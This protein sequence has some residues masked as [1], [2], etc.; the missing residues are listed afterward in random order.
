MY[1]IYPLI[2]HAAPGPVSITSFPSFFKI[3]ITWN[4]PDIP[5]GIIIAYEVSYWA[6][7]SS[8]PVTTLNTTDLATSFTTQS[9][10]EV[11]TEFIFTVRAYTQ[12]GPGNSTSVVVSTLT[13]PCKFI[14]LCCGEQFVEYYFNFTSAA[15]VQGV[16]V[17]ALCD[18]VIIVSWKALIIPDLSIDY[19]TV[20]YSQVS[21][22]HDE[23]MSVLFLP[24]V[25]S[26]VITDLHSSVVYQFQVFITVSMDG[27]TLEGERSTPAYFARPCKNHFSLLLLMCIVLSS[28]H[29]QLQYKK[30]N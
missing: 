7:D 17:T 21:Q 20:V 19:Y 9:G 14:Y 25:T 23:E 29:A 26:G 5:N 3:H 27:N 16:G 13:A 15:A 30:W 12:V 8:Q 11:G 28:L 1:R 4:P 22:Q 10:L 2:T 24:S 18:T 6:I